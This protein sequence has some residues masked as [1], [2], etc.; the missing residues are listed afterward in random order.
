M[1]GYLFSVP[2]NNDIE[3]LDQLLAMKDH[4]G[5]HIREVYLAAPEDII[6]SG[7]VGK[8]IGLEGFLATLQRI[9]AAGVETDMTM[10]STCEGSDWYESAT[11]ARQLDFIRHAHEDHAVRAV[12]LA[13]PFFIEKVRAACPD[14]EIS[15]S[16]LADIDCFSRAETFAQAGANV[17][18]VDV[19]INR[20]LKLL[21]QIV[22]K[23]KVEL[24]LMVNEGCLNKCPYRKFHMN[25]ISHRSKETRDEGTGFSFACGDLTKNDPG[26]IF[27]SNWIRPEDLRRYADITRFFKIVG[28]DMLKSKVLRC[29]GAYM[30][31]SYEGNLLDL[32]CSNIGCY[33]IEYSA[34]ID[35][36]ALDKTSFFKRTST[37][38]RHC[39]TCDY[40]ASLAEETLGYG[41]ISKENLEDL[42][43]FSLVELVRSQF[44]GEFPVCQEFTKEPR[45]GVHNDAS[46][47]FMGNLRR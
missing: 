16:V 42:G 40:C 12:T 1:P 24:K 8:V 11:I 38:N 6:G 36:K 47:T 25:Y 9:H 21:A 3:T 27:K 31:E 39:H 15:A 19:S 44:R 46:D 41:W 23:L 5:N 29:V 32:L 43:Q 17:L 18:T 28:R 35:N 22:R 34:H 45:K 30:D 37:C 20:D 2:Y 13:N 7:R 4:G 10:N 14:I 33:G 26:Q